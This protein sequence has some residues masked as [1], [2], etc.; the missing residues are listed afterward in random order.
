M[1]VELPKTEQDWTEWPECDCH[2]SFKYASLECVNKCQET[3]M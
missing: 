1:E 2:S 3:V